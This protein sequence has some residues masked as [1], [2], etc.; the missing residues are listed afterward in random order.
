MKHSIPD[1]L[2]DSIVTDV[3]TV[4]E[5]AKKYYK[6]SRFTERGPEYVE[7]I[8]KSMKDDIADRGYT[9]ISKHGSITGEFITFVPEMYFDR[10]AEFK[11]N[12]IAMQQFIENY[13]K[14]TKV[15]NGTATFTTSAETF[16]TY[17]TFYD[18]IR[19]IDI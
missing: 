9:C 5:F 19:K 1:Y 2:S 17:L 6:P 16:D 8:L 11:S 7:A 12:Y 15:K 4:E 18:K 14:W 3:K 13:L 10:M